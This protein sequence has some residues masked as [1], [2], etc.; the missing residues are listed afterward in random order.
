MRRASITENLRHQRLP[1]RPDL[2]AWQEFEAG[3][4]QAGGLRLHAPQW[5]NFIAY[6]AWWNNACDAT[7]LHYWGTRLGDEALVEKARRM[8][9]LALSAPQN[10][11]L[12][13]AVFDL[14]E[15]RWLPSLWKPPLAGYDPAARA[16]YW[17]WTADSDYQTAAAS[18]TAGYLMEYRRSCEDDGRILPYVRGY[19][20]FLVAAMP[21]TG[22]VPGWFSHELES[23]P[24]LAWNADGGA[25]AWVLA[26]LFLAT[27]E[28][29]Y[30]DAAERAAGFLIAEVMPR[31]RWADFEAFYSCAIKP[32]TFVDARTGQWP[33][34]TMAMSWA[35]QGFLALHE[36][37]QDRKYLEAAEAVAD[38]ASLF[39]AC[40]APHYVIT[41]Y[42]FG[43]VSSQLGDAD[44]LDQRAHRF[45]DPFVRLGMLTGRQ[46]LVERGVA[47]ARSSLTLV[48]HPRHRDNG[49]YTHTDFPEGLGPE[50]VDHEGFPQR[51]LASGPSWS[52]VGGLAGIA[53][54]M[55]RLGGVH[56]DFDS[57]IAVGVDGV[58]V[59]AFDRSGDTIRLT[60]ESQLA[61]LP[62]PYDRPYELE[63][64]VVGL[65]A[66]DYDL[67]INDEPAR[68]LSA[69]ELTSC[70]IAAPRR[71][72][73]PRSP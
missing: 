60:L 52:S 7:G 12:F 40:W 65:P 51:P 73:T 6:L 13:P 14:R 59:A 49:V 63:L 5:A 15:R 50:N 20:D 9:N 30:L 32:E 55:R 69:A 25:H 3:G 27:G 4:A 56:V 17:S 11:G 42:P 21:A 58:R 68:R 47:A 53:H 35:L 43:G 72:R 61:E 16:A 62:A 24:S 64:R 31:Q 23:L 22:C 48:A 37:T 2:L 67:V 29:K 33:C 71:T 70:R 1:D 66:G 38:F 34:N 19:G 18:V 26:E 28:R 8:V 45:A 54:V 10:R 57:G 36:A 39:Q 44:W 46:D 41:A